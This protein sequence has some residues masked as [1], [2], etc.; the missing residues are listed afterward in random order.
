MRV[1]YSGEFV[2]AAPWSVAGQG[3]ANVSHGCT[4]MSTANADWLYHM[5]NVGDVVQYTGTDKPMTSPTATATGT[6]PS[7]RTRPAPPSTNADPPEVC[8]PD[9]PTRQSRPRLSTGMRGRWLSGEDS[10]HSWT[11]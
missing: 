10:G 8:G 5:T 3:H 1:T 9:A 7:R 11:P 2:H 6:S 4:G